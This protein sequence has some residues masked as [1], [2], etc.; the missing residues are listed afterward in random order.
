MNQSKLIQNSSINLSKES[1]DNGAGG[2]KNLFDSF[3]ME[4][5][6]NE[7]H[8]QSTKKQNPPAKEANDTLDLDDINIQEEIQRQDEL[9]KDLNIKFTKPLDNKGSA[10]L[11]PTVI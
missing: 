11:Q 4:L 9:E 10:Q 3:K 2:Q 8:Q 6:S 1:L 7:Q 5:F